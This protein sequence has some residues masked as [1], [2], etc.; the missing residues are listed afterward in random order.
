MRWLE[1]IKLIVPIV[2]PIVN[3][4]LAPLAPVIANG[5][6]EAEQVPGA[7]GAEKLQHVTNLAT[8]AAQGINAVA[9]GTV[10][11]QHV[12]ETVQAAIGTIVGVTNILHKNQAPTPPVVQ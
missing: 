6:A 4:K 7:S 8:T 10:D 1:L 2:I 11:E 12:N 5:I 9:P 3:P